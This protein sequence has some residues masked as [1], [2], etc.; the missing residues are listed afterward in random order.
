TDPDIIRSVI[1]IDELLN[2][3]ILILVPHTDQ[4]SVILSA[5]TLS[6]SPVHL[7]IDKDES[8]VHFKKNTWKQIHES[9]C[10]LLLC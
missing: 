3:L 10:L 6:V 7:L 5:V 1:I 4:I 9:V 8:C 2:L